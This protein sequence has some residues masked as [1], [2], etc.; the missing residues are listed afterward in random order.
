M[1][2]TQPLQGCHVFKH[3]NCHFLEAKII[4]THIAGR[5]CM[6]LWS[7]VLQCLSTDKGMREGK[8]EE[9]DVKKE[10]EKGKH[11]NKVR[12]LTK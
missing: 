4:T 9:Q 5:K 3:S 2:T 10:R 8:E 12:I 1:Y 7:K 11:T 6:L